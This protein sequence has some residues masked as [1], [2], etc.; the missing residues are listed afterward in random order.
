M[1][2]TVE[3]FYDDGEAT[4][5][6]LRLGGQFRCF[7]LEDQY[8]SEKVAGETRI[9]TGYYDVKL[10]MEGGFHQRYSNHPRIGPIHKGMLEL[11]NVPGFTY[12]L[13]H[14][15]NTDD[16]TAGCLLVGTTA[17]PEPGGPSKVGRSVDAYMALYPEI[18]ATL[19]AGGNVTIKIEDRDR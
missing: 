10:R 13:I 17:L 14:C 8:Q 9:P 4:L 12:I 1:L 5:G 15:G 11:Q 18:A 16:H 2:I 19:E 3:R 6:I 7:T